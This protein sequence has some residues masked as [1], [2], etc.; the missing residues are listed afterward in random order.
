MQ[1]RRTPDGLLG[2][3]DPVRL[4]GSCHDAAKNQRNRQI[5][6]LSTALDGFE[7]FDCAYFSCFHMRCDLLVRRSP[8]IA[9]LRRKL[10]RSAVLVAGFAPNNGQRS[11]SGRFMGESRRK[12]LWLKCVIFSPN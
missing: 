9:G 11:T 2:L 10:W 1:S 4:C 5:A 3:V 6:D 12:S 8:A 7:F